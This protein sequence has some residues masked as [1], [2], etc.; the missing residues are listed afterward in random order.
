MKFIIAALVIV[1][2]SAG[3]YALGYRHGGE[4]F[5]YMDHV[6]VGA[7]S[8]GEVSYCDNADSPQECYKQLLGLDTQHAVYFFNS[9]GD[10]LSPLAKQVFPDAHDGYLTALSL[11][12]DRLL[13]EGED[14]FCVIIHPEKGELFQECMSEVARFV[15]SAESHINN[16]LKSGT[17]KIGAP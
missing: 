8:R 1:V 7:V 4:D 3:I 17:P 9:S 14:E 15:L 2:A 10:S 11:L 16:S 5:V 6:M 12:H 13:E